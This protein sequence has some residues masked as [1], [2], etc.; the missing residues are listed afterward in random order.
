MGNNASF[1]AHSL[2]LD[3]ALVNKFH[4]DRVRDAMEYAS[5][6]LWSLSGRKYN[7]VQCTIEQ[8]DTTSSLAF[9]SQVYPMFINGTPYNVSGCSDCPCNRCGVFHRT[10]LR[11]YPVH[12][13]VDVWLNGRLLDR[14]EY[15]LLDYA[16]LG[17]LTPEACGARCL[18]VKYAF[19]T[20]I[21]PGGR[22]AAIKLAENL[23]RASAGEACDLPARVTSVSRQGVTFTLLDPQDFLDKGLTGIYEVDLLLRSLNP[24]GA[25]KRPRVFSPDLQR[26]EVRNNPAPPPCNGVKD[27]WL[28]HMD[29]DSRLTVI[30]GLQGGQPA[31]G[32][33][34]IGDIYLVQ[35]GGVTSETW[36]FGYDTATKQR[37]WM[38][39]TKPPVYGPFM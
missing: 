9:G 4:E 13:I 37:M 21:P 31:V 20:G 17:L 16:V 11:G 24:A 30:T 19:G 8:Y 5:Y 26:A 22:M 32:Q 3:S 15:V 38:Q 1:W 29:P 34:H 35:Q 12:G 23:L 36:V 25:L 2:D 33:S 39:M 6:V 18:V 10:R 27:G 28:Q 7:P 14:S